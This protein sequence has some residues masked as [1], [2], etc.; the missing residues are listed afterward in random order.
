[1]CAWFCW[2]TVGVATPETVCNYCKHF[3]ASVSIWDKFF[4]PPSSL[5][6]MS[7][8]CVWHN[9]YGLEVNFKYFYPLTHMLLLVTLPTAY[10]SFEPLTQRPNSKWWCWTGWRET[11]RYISDLN[12]GWPIMKHKKC[13]VLMFRKVS[14]FKTLISKWQ[15][16]CN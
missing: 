6:L 14:P 9:C 3:W 1:M 7:A 2:G 10:L 13:S 5:D 4:L 12:L 15:G 11:T 16:C 8:G